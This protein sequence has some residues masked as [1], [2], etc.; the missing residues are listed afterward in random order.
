MTKATNP[1]LGYLA[2]LTK[3]APLL[4]RTNGWIEAAE[5]IAQFLLEERPALAVGF[6]LADPSDIR[7]AWW[8][9]LAPWTACRVCR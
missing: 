9:A 6:W 2:A 3:A 7:H 1:A 5:G 4:S 8:R